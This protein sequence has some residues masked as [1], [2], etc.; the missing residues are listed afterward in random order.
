[1]EQTYML[2]NLYCQY[3][4]CWSTG[5]SRSQGINR[6]GTDQNIPSPASEELVQ[7]RPFIARFIIAN[8]L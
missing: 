8:I 4:G 5:D 2:P 1:M 7:W 3:H 6:H